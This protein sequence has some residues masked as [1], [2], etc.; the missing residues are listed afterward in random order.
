MQKKKNWYLDRPNPL[1]NTVHYNMV[2]DIT[3]L[4]D[5]PQL[6]IWDSFSYI[7]YTF[8]SWYNTVWIANMDFDLDPKNSIIK[9]FWCVYL[10][11]EKSDNF[12]QITIP[13]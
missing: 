1:Y 8:Y 3:R 2:L 6:G 7:T 5:G 11:K 10:N 13:L 12:M 9:R 4:R